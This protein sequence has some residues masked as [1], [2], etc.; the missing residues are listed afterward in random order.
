MHCEGLREVVFFFEKINEG[1][2]QFSSYIFRFTISFPEE[3][4]LMETA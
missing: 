1:A 2:K 4:R 3:V